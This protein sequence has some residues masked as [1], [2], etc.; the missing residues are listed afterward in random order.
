MLIDE[1]LHLLILAGLRINYLD[2][3][4]SRKR[5]YY[6]FNEKVESILLIIFNIDSNNIKLIFSFDERKN[7]D[8]HNSIKSQ[9]SS[10]P[11]LLS[12]IKDLGLEDRIS[13]YYSKI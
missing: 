6:C 1:L 11:Q 4:D 2:Y 13:K 12:I 3:E 7:R 8:L 10:K 9:I 5:I